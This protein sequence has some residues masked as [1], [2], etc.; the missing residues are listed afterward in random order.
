MATWNGGPWVGE[1]VRSVLSQ[2]GVQVFL[3]VRDDAST[4]DTVPTVAALATDER[5]ILIQRADAAGG[6]AAANFFHLIEAADS[7]GHDFV[8]LCDQDDIWDPDKL[9]RAAD[10]LSEN[11]ADAYSAA[12]RAFWPD[13]RTAVLSQRFKPTSA[14]YLFEGAGQGCT[15]VLR[16]A[17][18]RRLQLTLRSHSSFLGSIHYHDWLI[19]ALC[20]VW[21]GRWHYDD[22]ACLQYRQH[23]ANDTG[24]RT[25][26]AAVRK[27]LSRIR[28]GWYGAQVAAIA[29]L[30]MAVDSGP[31]PAAAIYLR[32]LGKAASGT[33][34]LALCG[35]VLRC[36]RRR[37]SD[38]L[39]LTWAAFNGHLQRARQSCMRKT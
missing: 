33:G 17:F 3:T 27:R 19:Y 35:F 6:S 7:A 39:V 11:G 4:D 9:V 22:R 36:G 24:A 38:R 29:R 34:R 14:D 13:G 20:R 15:F 37:W 5:P 30:C 2:H 8:A 23:A 16:E 18:F 26:L 10:A 31:A 21:G 12:V 1:Q 28:S 25:G 32:H